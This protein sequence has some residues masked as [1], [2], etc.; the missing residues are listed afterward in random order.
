MDLLIGLDLLKR[1]Q[2]TIDLKVEL[3]IIIQN[4]RKKQNNCLTIGT[5]NQTV[6]FLSEGQLDAE[7]RLS[8]PA[9]DNAAREEMVSFL[10]IAV[11]DSYHLNSSDNL[12][13]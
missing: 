11:F 13:I 10:L 4:L 2:C 3:F 9:A 6:Q 8:G 5:T 7:A 1:H 12:K